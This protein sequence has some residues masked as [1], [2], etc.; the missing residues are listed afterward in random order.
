ME[1]GIK[2]EYSEAV[3]LNEGA[4]ATVSFTNLHTAIRINLRPNQARKKTSSTL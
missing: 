1:H 3:V 2:R 4:V